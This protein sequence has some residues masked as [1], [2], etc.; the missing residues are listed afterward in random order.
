MVK[1]LISIL[2]IAFFLG[3]ICAVNA[4]AQEAEPSALEAVTATVEMSIAEVERM[5]ERMNKLSEEMNDLR[6]QFGRFGTVD[7]L[8]GDDIEALVS[9]SEDDEDRWY[10]LQ[11]AANRDEMIIDYLQGVDLAEYMPEERRT[12][13]GL[14]NLNVTKLALSGYY[15]VRSIGMYNLDTRPDNTDRFSFVEQ[16]L[17]VNTQLHPTRRSVIAAQIN[18]LDGV[19]YGDNGGYGEGEVQRNSGVYLKPNQPNLATYKVRHT[20]DVFFDENGNVIQPAHSRFISDPAGYID[21]TTGYELVPQAPIEIQRL[22]GRVFLHFAGIQIGR[23]PLNF[24]GGGISANDGETPP[25][26]GVSKYGTTYDQIAF[27]TKPLEGI[28]LLMSGGDSSVVDPSQDRGLFFSI[29]MAK[30]SEGRPETDYDDANQVALQFSYLNPDLAITDSGKDRLRADFSYVDI[31]QKSYDTDMSAF[32]GF[33]SLRLSDFLIQ[34]ES[35]YATGHSREFDLAQVESPAGSYASIF[36]GEDNFPVAAKKVTQLGLRSI[37][38]YKIGRQI[39]ELE[40]DYA[41]GDDDISDDNITVTIFAPETK[42]GLILFPQLMAFETAK[43]A[44]FA[45]TALLVD[46]TDA[47]DTRGGVSNAI[48]IFPKVKLKTD[49]LS[50]VFGVMVAYA[51]KPVVDVVAT[52]ICRTQDPLFERFNY[53]G[54]KPGKYYGTELDARISMALAKNVS[55]ELEGGYLFSGDA[56]QNSAGKAENVYLGEARLTISY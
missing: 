29:M 30:L 2:C 5:Q 18:V 53:H 33:V 52:Q 1:K 9:G 37:L 8:S 3:T 6:F 7:K 17:R 38:Q 23:A 32:L 40:F 4:S 35:L 10:S 16:R 55:F 45:K 56:L 47:V 20:G 49:G 14:L 13:K 27:V 50:G 41:T 31:G 54:G 36:L 46:V 42:V 19:I 15:R 12:M 22:W 51:E 43:S 28:K 21:D 39:F 25:D 26:F 24:A 44:A 48:V 11:G 34:M